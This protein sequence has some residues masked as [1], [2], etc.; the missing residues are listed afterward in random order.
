[1]PF[2]GSRPTNREVILVGDVSADSH[3][4]DWRELAARMATGST[5]VF[6]SPKAFKKE[7]NS[8]AWL[9]LAKKGRAYEFSDMLYHKECVV[10]PHR[11]FGG[12]QGNGMLDWYYWGPMWPHFLFDG[13]DTPNEVFAAAFAT[14]YSTPGGYASGVL[15]ASTN[16]APENLFSI[17]SPCLNISTNIRQRT[18]CS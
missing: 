10:K 5:V 16:S 2:G 3:P 12:L 4:G 11:M 1:M 8:T 15:L 9:P 6:L 18:A 17:H 14:G 7:K 13:Q